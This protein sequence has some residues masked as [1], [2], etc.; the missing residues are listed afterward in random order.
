MKLVEYKVNDFLNELASKSPAPGGGSVAAL[1]GSN[2]ASLVSMVG[3]LTTKRKKFKALPEEKQSQYNDY[4]DY[5]NNAKNDFTRY[6]DEDTE[7]F[8]LVMAAF[9]L[10]KETDNDVQKRNEAIQ[11]GTIQCIKTPMKVATLAK[12]CLSKM[13]YIIQN[14]NRNTVSD[15]GV[16]VL[17]FYTAFVGAIM[18][19]KINLPGLNKLELAKEYKDVI[20]VMENEVEDLKDKLLEHV[21]TL[22]N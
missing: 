1:S 10:P 17:S 19:V 6:I 15:Q 12:Q 8:N 3:A 22:L 20:I 9:K 11:L 5:F 13:E 21:E 18:N 14:S 2:G 4:I 7:A 16:A